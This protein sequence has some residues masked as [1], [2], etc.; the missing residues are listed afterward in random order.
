MIDKEKSRK[1]GKPESGERS[2][3]SKRSLHNKLLFEMEHKTNTE[4]SD[5]N[6]CGPF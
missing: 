6:Q 5:D 1:K 2:P 3:E 4:I